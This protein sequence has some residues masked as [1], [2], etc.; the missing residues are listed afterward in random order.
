ME[1]ARIAN[2][3]IEE[4][5]PWA[6]AKAEARDPAAGAAL[7]ETLATLARTLAVLAALFQPVAPAKM[8]DLSSRLGLDA[9]P[10]LEAARAVDMSGR[11]VTKGEALFPKVDPE[12]FPDS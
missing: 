7:D 10:T 8:S 5:Q 4:R 9:V 11:R 1:L 3:W 12:D 2:G 6:L